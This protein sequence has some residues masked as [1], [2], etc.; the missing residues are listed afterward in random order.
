M[1]DTQITFVEPPKAFWFPMGEYIPPPF[2]ILCLAAYIEREI[3]SV[4]IEVIDSQ[5]E[6]LDWTGLTRRIKKT[7]PDIVAPAGLSTCNSM[8]SL[9]TANITKEI[10]P[11]IKTIIGGQH[12]T[13]LA[14]ETLTHTH[15]V[16]A[17][18][19]GEG[20]QT[21]LEYVKASRGDISIEEISGLS[22][23]DG[24]SIYHNKERDLICDLDTLPYP[25]YHFVANHMKDYHFAL[26]AEEDTPFAIVEGSRGCNHTCSYCSQ[27]RYWNGGQ[28]TKSP[29]RVAEEI[30]YLYKEY[31]SK[32]FWLTDDDL[33]INEWTVKF[34][35][36][37][38]S[39]GLSDEITW[40]CQARCDNIVASREVLPKMKR[41]GNTW[42]LIGFDTPNTEDLKSFRRN[43]INEETSKKAV[44]LLRANGIFSQGTF[45]IGNRND[46]RESI[47]SI[48]VYADN[49]DP[50]IATFMVLTPFPGTEIYDIAKSNGWIKNFDWSEYD[51]IHAIMPTKYL[52]VEE[53]QEEIYKSYRFFFGSRTRRY[54]A[55]FSTN[56]ITKKVYRYLAKKA[57]LTN[58]RN[59]F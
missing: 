53:V 17:I 41:A 4:N 21:L 59:L 49:L 1:A 14:E 32:F 31:G 7:S 45:I 34:C 6:K 3:D 13:A 12:F 39:L 26:M 27:W 16:D 55:L 25:G 35:D 5:S 42:M 56:P 57:I 22:Y 8:H 38:I 19:R 40:F 46:D 29:R 36:E 54:R 33:S 48:N 43:D 11:E 50:D 10:D 15:Q 23:R 51:M 30:D 37:I 9:R 44:D 20:E 24:Q 18:A 58:L 2:G 47:R 52:N 28:R